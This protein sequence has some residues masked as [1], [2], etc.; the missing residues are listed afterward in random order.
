MRPSVEAAISAS[1]RD[2]REHVWP[3]L[4]GGLG[5]GDLVPVETVSDSMFTRLLDMEAGIDAWQVVTGEGI[6]GIASRIQWGGTYWESWTVRTRRPSGVRTE[7]DKLI[8]A[9]Q[10][11][12]RPSYHVQA[13]LDGVGGAVLGAAA[14]RTNDLVRLLLAEQHG[15]ERFNPVDGAAFVPVWWQAAEEAGF[16]VW[17]A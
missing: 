17:R 7:R 15:S 9:D 14:I 12:L 1:A 2:F 13:Y 6:R 4:A 10:T 3:L 8:H 16:E 5:G 11:L